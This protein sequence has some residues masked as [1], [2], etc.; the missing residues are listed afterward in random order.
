[1]IKVL[2]VEDDVLNQ[3]LACR[4]LT[5]CGL[6]VTIAN[7]G[8]EAVQRIQEQHFDLVL[9]DL[10]MPQ[11]DGC[12]ATTKIRALDDPYYKNVPILAFTSSTSEEIRRKASQ[13]GMNDF[14]PKPF[15]REQMIMKLNQYLI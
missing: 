10:Q 3:K 4:L 6:A 12:E 13:H 2:L 5:K 9:M 11:M 1:M 14:L 7:D 8:V 15:N